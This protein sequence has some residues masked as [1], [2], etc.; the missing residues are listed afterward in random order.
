[1]IYFRVCQDGWQA[2]VSCQIVRDVNGLCFTTSLFFFEII[3]LISKCLFPAEPKEDR[4]STTLSPPSVETFQAGGRV[5]SKT[6][7]FPLYSCFFFLFVISYCPI[8][9]LIFLKVM[10]ITVRQQTSKTVPTPQHYG[11]VTR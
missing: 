4:L 5:L 3:C 11:C 6:F 9:D 1:M 2:C 10:A 8:E 7:P